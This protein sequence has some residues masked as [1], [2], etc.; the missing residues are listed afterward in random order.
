V[1][2]R[3]NV[4]ER[5]KGKREKGGNSASANCASPREKEK[6]Q[7]P[8]RKGGKRGSMRLLSPQGGKRKLARRERKGEG[9]KRREGMSAGPLSH[10]L[11]SKSKKNEEKKKGT[12][13]NL[14]PLER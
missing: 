13:T 14:P 5:G 6:V 3:K 11:S 2:L 8:E 7:V 4:L 12:R 10:I 9:R 1:S